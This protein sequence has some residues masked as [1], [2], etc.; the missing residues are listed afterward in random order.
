MDK[1]Y[2]I[3]KYNYQYNDV[4][5]EF[6]CEGDIEYVSNNYEEAYAT[7]YARELKALRTAELN[8]VEILGITD[9]DA[10]AI[11]KQE[12]HEYMQINFGISLFRFLNADNTPEW[13]WIEM[14]E[15]AT[16]EQLWEIRR[17]TGM[18]F[19]SLTTFDETDSFY[20]I[21]V[22]KPLVTWEE[23]AYPP[24]E[25]GLVTYNG[26]IMFFNSPEDAMNSLGQFIRSCII[27]GTLEELSDMPEVLR[28]LIHMN[29]SM[30]RY[31]ETTQKLFVSIPHRQTDNSSMILGQ[32]F[33]LLK[34][35]LVTLHRMSLE[36]AR[37]IRFFTYE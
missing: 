36:E 13:F 11:S 3:R 15:S 27:P 12:L 23:G 18:R 30:L 9:D 21:G 7:W 37:K 24:H 14:P 10:L 8:H 28:Q 4:Y 26:E 6:E 1:T 22:K 34:E 20:T 31:D 33:Q 17:I 29:E 16:D 19:Y 35:P 25:K 2:I 32:V 5:N